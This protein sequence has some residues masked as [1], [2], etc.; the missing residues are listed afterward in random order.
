MSNEN[1]NIDN[2]SVIKCDNAGVKF[3]TIKPFTTLSDVLETKLSRTKND[4]NSKF[5]WALKDV[6]FTVKKGEMVG[7]IGKNGSGKSTLLRVIAEILPLDKGKIEVNTKC[8]LLSPGVGLR[9][10]LSGRDNIFLGCLM[11]GSSLQQIK[12][13]YSSIVEFSELGEHIERPLRYYSTG[14]RSRLMFTIAT[15]IKPEFLLLDELLS[16]GDISF[17]GKANTRMKE[18]ITSS[19]GGVIATH[20]L[21]FVKESCNKALYLSEGELKFFGNAEKCVDMYLEDNK[22]SKKRINTHD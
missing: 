9:P 17:R 12:K 22:I 5:F 6:S 11:I 14:M 8:T 1:L 15:S 20:D 7:L 16:G 4:K 2:E 21:G 3:A 18:V 13:N 19:N 10:E